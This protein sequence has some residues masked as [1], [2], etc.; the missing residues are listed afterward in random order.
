MITVI[1]NFL[2]II[3]AIFVVYWFW[4]SQAKIEKIQNNIATIT[5]KDEGYKAKL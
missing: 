1:V 5:V 2:L 3:I 4:L